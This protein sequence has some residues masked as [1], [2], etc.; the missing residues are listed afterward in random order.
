M[1]THTTPAPQGSAMLQ[2]QLWGPRAHDW[3]ELQEPKVLPL[4]R[5]AL[6]SLQLSPHS[7]VLDAGC[8]AGLFCSLVIE[9]GHLVT[10]FDATPALLDIAQQRV[11]QGIFFAGDFEQLPLADNSFDVVTGFN[12]FQ[13][14]SAPL[15]A[16]QEAHRVL[17]PGGQLLMATWG[18]PSECE[19]ETY[20][21]ALGA[22]LP[23]Q[24]PGTPGPF[25]LSV[26]G[27]LVALTREAGFRPTAELQT[28]TIWRY[29]DETTTLRGLMSAGPAVR[30]INHAG[31]ST[32]FNAVRT[33]LHR[34][35]QPEGD[36]R[37]RN[38]FR[39]VIARK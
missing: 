9:A 23:P 28:E 13:Y 16:L 25:A 27:A 14:A 32:A 15:K 12:S 22:L 18:K 19:A 31:E 37:L 29:P 2:S 34:F 7:Q 20:L 36:Y 3:A 21:R 30:A 24:L 17:K 6:V 33:I 35:R 38:V 4:Y 39:Y 5:D 10:G 8:G 11:P 1:F 26:D